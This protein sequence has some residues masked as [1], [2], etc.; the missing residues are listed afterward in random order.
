MLRHGYEESKTNA[1]DII[2]GTELKQLQSGHNRGNYYF[3]DEIILIQNNCFVYSSRQS[4]R[5]DTVDTVT[6]AEHSAAEIINGKRYLL[7]NLPGQL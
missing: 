4:L 2:A 5:N 3:T 6:P 1:I 7:I